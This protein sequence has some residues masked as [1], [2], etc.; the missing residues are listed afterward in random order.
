M[1]TA[2]SSIPVH[3]APMESD[4]EE[5]F[6]GGLTSG[7]SGLT[8]RFSGLTSEIT[9]K[10]LFGPKSPSAG[11]SSCGSY[12]KK[13]SSRKRKGGEGFA[14]SMNTMAQEGMSAAQDQV[15]YMNTMA[16][17]GMSAAQDQVKSMNTMAPK[18]GRRRKSMKKGKKHHK[19]SMKK[20]KKHHKKSMK[21]GKKH[22]KKSMKKGK[23]SRM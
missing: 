12:D 6:L 17:Q 23:K 16:Q 22:H 8:S 4:K 10:S 15:K 11:G 7:F 2:S 5:S 3:T 9:G 13:R 1:A 14:K 18:G 21:K 20:G 19:K